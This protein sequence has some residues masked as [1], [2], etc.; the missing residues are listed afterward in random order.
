MSIVEE[1]GPESP[2]EARGKG[3]CAVVARSIIVEASWSWQLRKAS[4]RGMD[5][6]PE[7]VQARGILPEE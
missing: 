2:T 5:A 3:Q 6:H 7:D 1:T 4:T